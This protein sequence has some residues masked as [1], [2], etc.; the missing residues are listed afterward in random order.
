MTNEKRRYLE[1]SKRDAE[2]VWRRPLDL[3]R[4]VRFY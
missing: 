4:E 2:G 3:L 1:I